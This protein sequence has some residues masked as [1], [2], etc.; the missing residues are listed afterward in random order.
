MHCKGVEEKTSPA[1]LLSNT[2]PSP[3]LIPVPSAATSVSSYSSA[4]D[5]GA[6]APKTFY[7]GETWYLPTILSVAEHEANFSFTFS[8]RT[9]HV[10]LTLFGRRVIAH[11]PS[12]A[13][14]L[15]LL[16]ALWF[17]FY[18][19]D[20]RSYVRHSGIVFDTTCAV[21]FSAVVGG[22]LSTF[23]TCPPLAGILWA[24]FLWGNIPTQFELVEGFVS[25][26][27]KI[28]SRV[29]LTIIIARCGLSVNRAQT[30]AQWKN[31]ISLG[32]LPLSVEATVHAFM[33]SWLFGTSSLKLAFMQGFMAAAV[34]PAVV[35][36][37]AL[38]L[39]KQGR[40]VS[41]GPLPLALSS[42]II[43]VSASVWVICFLMDL[44]FSSRSVFLNVALGPIQI[45]GGG[46]VGF[47]VAVVVHLAALC[48]TKEN[49][50]THQSEL[51]H[52]VAIRCAALFLCLCIGCMFLG[53]KENLAGG[54]TVAVAVASVA[55]MWL[56]APGCRPEVA[57]LRT[58][59]PSLVTTVWD[60]VALPFLF[61]SAGSQIPIST[62]FAR[63]F[64][65]RALAC[66]G[67]GIASRM[68]ATLL[69]G[70]G[71][72]FSLSD[73]AVLVVSWLAKASTQGALG[74]APNQRAKETCFESPT[75]NCADE[76]RDTAT[77]MKIALLEILLLAPIG[78][79][80]FGLVGKRLLC[81]ER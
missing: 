79:V 28:I 3:I 35:V 77:I 13:S 4:V 15:V 37:T 8:S 80:A 42:V 14:R 78:A 43:D 12:S 21:V 40:S 67:A 22:T 33:A 24:A 1:A 6:V 66:I 65:G 71:L 63:D 64:I 19:G 16:G 34:A 72:D 39:Q 60:N 58:E 32:L 7:G 62:V 57:P 52:Q 20:P 55:L 10:E 48:W 25:D 75:R 68:L 38:A 49:D 5:L 51:I 76:L 27:R 81:V 54:S 2:Q 70:V 59:V 26:L 44:C 17:L 46:V 69:C 41:R 30:V 53:F 31:A 56:W 61:T 29:G 9:Q 11:L 74:S 73:F 50:L 23:A 45:V 47:V 18:Y 36:P